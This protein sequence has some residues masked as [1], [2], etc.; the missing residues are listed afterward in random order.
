MYWMKKILFLLLI[1]LNLNALAQAD[2]ES[3]E[4]DTPNLEET[5]QVSELEKEKAFLNP[6]IEIPDVV[7]LG[8]ETVFD[9]SP[10]KI[11]SLSDY[12]NPNYS[13]DFGDASETKF[14][15]IVKYAY[16]EAGVFRVRMNIK[17]GSERE[18]IEKDIQVYT[19]EM[20]LITDVLQEALAAVDAEAAEEGVLL[21]V[22]E[23]PKDAS[24]LSNEDSVIRKFQENLEVLK[25]AEAILFHTSSTQAMQAFGQFWKVVPLESQAELKN[26]LLVQISS[27][28]LDRDAKL[29]QPVYEIVQPEFI[30]LTRP[31]SL[32]PIFTKEDLDLVF[33][34]L[35]IRGIE[36]QKVDEK[37]RIPV[38]LPFSRL[39]NLFSS[40]GLSQ[41]VIYLLLSVPFLAFMIAFF[42]QF[43]GVS[44]FG[45]LAPLMLS[46]AFLVL[47]LQFGMA[48][49]LVVMLVSWGIRVLFDKVELL[50]IPKVA[51]LLSCLALSFFL[52]LGLAVYFEASL[53]LSLT[54]FP[55]MVMSSMSE[56]FLSSQSAEGSRSALIA[57]VETVLVSLIAYAFVDWALIRD[58]VLAMPEL[59]LLP[60]LGTIWLGK[61]T[62]LRVSEYIKFRSL[63]REDSQE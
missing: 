60:I 12:G 35:S 32:N 53:D 4:G 61:F 63:L 46:L 22:I 62:G 7:R 13:W 9:A 2:I 44:T 41:T 58:N 17:Q 24:D 26:K 28:S 15:E 29:I 57:V 27:S 23:V 51:L 30:V 52:V 42:R 6:A 21:N 18:S 1:G 8:D 38:Y 39:L 33:N 40:S 43:V 48:V 25:S 50:Y 55:M 37:S 19:K 49:F 56:K 14:G 5:P 47:G 54:I 31:E 45:V 10:S 3:A 36:V 59:I 20:V 34:E 16:P 11:M